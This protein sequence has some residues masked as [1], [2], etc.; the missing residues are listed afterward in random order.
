MSFKGNFL[1]SLG[2]NSKNYLDEIKTKIVKKFGVNVSIF[3]SKA[4]DQYQ[5]GI[6]DRVKEIP[7]YTFIRT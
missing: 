4:G 6:P 7:T 1:G 5:G 2:R 3:Q